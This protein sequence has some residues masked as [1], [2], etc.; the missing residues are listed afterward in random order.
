MLKN[1]YFK[2]KFIYFIALVF[3][4]SHKLVNKRDFM[5]KKLVFLIVIF[6]CFS[7]LFGCSKKTTLNEYVSELRSNCYESLDNDLKITAGYGFVEENNAPDGSVNKRYY[8]LTFRLF[9]VQTENVTYTLSLKHNGKDY[10][11]TFKLSPVLHGYTAGIEIDNFNANEFEITLSNGS[12]TTIVHMKSTLPKN[13]ISYKK[14]LEC[15]QDKQSNLIKSYYD[16]NGK[17]TAEI[18]AKIIVKDAHPYWYIGL[19]TKNSTKA[20]LIDGFNGELLAIRDV[21]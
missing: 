13:T 7:L 8:L 4:F 15:L 14:A 17:F 16:E 1:Q 21:F 6:C 5:R 3:I 11:Q 20:L 2:H 12:N 18:C 9:G 10:S 19:S